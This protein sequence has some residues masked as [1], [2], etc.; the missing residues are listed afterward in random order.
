[1]NI[2]NLAIA[3]TVVLGFAAGLLF[4]RFTGHAEQSHEPEPATS[5]LELFRQHHRY[6]GDG[7]AYRGERL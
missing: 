6:L 5:V 7:K 3:A 4:L 2:L 1:M